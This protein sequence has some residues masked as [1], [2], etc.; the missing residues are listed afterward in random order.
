VIGKLDFFATLEYPTIRNLCAINDGSIDLAL[1]NQHENVAFPVE[2]CME[3]GN[4]FIR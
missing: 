1:V 4:A 3:S 2:L